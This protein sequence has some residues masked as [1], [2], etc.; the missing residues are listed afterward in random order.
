MTT[1][2]DLEKFDPQGDYLGKDAGR[3]NA[4]L[5]AAPPGHPRVPAEHGWAGSLPGEPPRRSNPAG[6]GRSVLGRRG[7]VPQV[8]LGTVL[9]Q[10]PPDQ[11]APEGYQHQDKKLLH[12]AD[13]F[14]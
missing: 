12:G 11:E 13:P 9:L 7:F 1:L 5:E 10:P 3:R 2:R 14:T 6:V 8:Q 4:A